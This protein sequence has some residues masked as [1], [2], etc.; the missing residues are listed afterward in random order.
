MRARRRR[1]R[2]RRNSRQAMASANLPSAAPTAF[3]KETNM[4][5]SLPRWFVFLMWVVPFVSLVAVD[6]D[7]MEIVRLIKQ[8]GSDKFKE[9][10]AASKR[11]A[12]IG[13]P[14]LDALDK[15]A[16]SNDLEV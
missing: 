3:P 1:R 9:R 12:E 6:P 13:E 16:T 15:A 8:L 10:E 14:A 7:D 5:A 2:R 4:T 11:L